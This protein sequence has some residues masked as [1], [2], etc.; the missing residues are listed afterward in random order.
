MISLND[1]DRT[2]FNE[3]L[4]YLNF[5]SGS[6][7]LNFLKAWNDL[8][9]SFAA[10][11]SVQ[12]WSDVLDCLEERLET[13]AASSK[14]FQDS[15]QATIVISLVRE[16]LRKYR[17]FHV[18]VLFNLDNS[19]LYNSFFMARAC[20]AAITA[21]QKSE[22]EDRVDKIIDILND[23]IGY[24][25]VPV[26]EGGEKHEPNPHEWVA[27]LPLYADGVGCAF[28]P[29]SAV[30]EHTIELLKTTNPDVLFDASFDPDK[31]SELALDP[32][33]YDFDHPVNRRLNYSFGSWD[34][35]SVDKDGYFRRFIVQRSTVDGIMARV[36]NENNSELRKE[37]EY[38]AG[39]V[40]AGTILMASGVSGGRV[41][42]YDSTM[43][44]SVI[45]N[46]I[47]EYRDRFYEQ[48]IRKAPAG[49]QKRLKLG[50]SNLLQALDKL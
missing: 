29:Y 23:F 45:S 35:R 10:K 34:E 3:I 18:D 15:R 47:A 20:S 19:Y 39:A 11:G 46:K 40:L 49:I 36:W 12:I 48:L 16:A 25:P 22:G 1:N 14:A 26:L 28:G 4:G 37:Y 9:K 5:S 24:R 13:L 38:E 31:L 27:P 6:A 50:Y 17:D 33:A 7:D 41:Q 8:Y 43:S 21:S 44:L 42:A 30:V 32:R 2:L